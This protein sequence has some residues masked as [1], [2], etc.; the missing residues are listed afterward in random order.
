MRKFHLII[1]FLLCSLTIFAQNYITTTDVN[2]RAG[3]GTKFDIL[4]T[5]SN[6]STVKVLDKQGNWSKV[7]FNGSE[8][9]ISNNLIQKVNEE[10]DTSQTNNSKESNWLNWTV[11]I[12]IFLLLLKLFGFKKLFGLVFPETAESIYGKFTCQSC[13]KTQLGRDNK[14]CPNGGRH[15]WYKM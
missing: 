8:G 10:Q 1:A 15:E 14:T 13:G 11:G 2:V 12:I 9:F 5:L 4:G 6:G 3:A 7:E